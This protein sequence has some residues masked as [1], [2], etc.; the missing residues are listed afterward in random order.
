MRFTSGSWRIAVTID[1]NS[2]LVRCNI[3]DHRLGNIL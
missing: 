1:L 2:D 3:D